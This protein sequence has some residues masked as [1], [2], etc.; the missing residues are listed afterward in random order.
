MLRAP[1]MSIFFVLHLG[2]FFVINLNASDVFVQIKC[3][4]NVQMPSLDIKSN[5]LLMK[6]FQYEL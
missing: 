4:I 5:L 1:F 6:M 2:I 3:N